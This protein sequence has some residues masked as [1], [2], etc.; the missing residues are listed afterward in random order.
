MPTISSFYGITI[1]MY[2]RD[3]EHMPPHIHAVM[4]DFAAPFLLETAEIMEGYF[5]PKAKSMVKDFITKYR[6][7]LEEMWES[8][9]YRKLPPIT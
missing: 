2:L 7:E 5:P 8:G 6:S 1:I 4:Q 9:S 3:K